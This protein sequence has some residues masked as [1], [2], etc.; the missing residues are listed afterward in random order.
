MPAAFA[1]IPAQH[2]DDIA[3]SL[4]ITPNERLAHEFSNAFDLSKL[5]AGATVW[6]SLQCMS[7]RRF[8]QQQFHQLLSTDLNQPRLLTEQEVNLRFQQSAPEGYAQQ[9]RTAVAAWQLVRGYDIDLHGPQMGGERG[10]YFNIYALPCPEEWDVILCEAD[11]LDFRLPHYTTC[12]NSSAALSA[13]RC[14]TPNVGGDRVFPA[15]GRN[16]SIRQYPRGR[17]MDHW[18]SLRPRF[19]AALHHHSSA[20]Q[21]LDPSDTALPSVEITGYDPW[22]S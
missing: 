10:Q 1:H 9:C 18:V 17:Q 4:V 12:R 21:S 3:D 20:Q 6:P 15:I 7:L 2:L 16:H 5:N 19:W 14:R 13:D 11:L 22:T 8:W